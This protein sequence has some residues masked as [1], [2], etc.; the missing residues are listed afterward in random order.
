MRCI[1]QLK[2]VFGISPPSKKYN[3]PRTPEVPVSPTFF[4]PVIGLSLPTGVT[5]NLIFTVINS[6]VFLN[7]FLPLTYR[8]FLFAIFMFHGVTTNTKLANVEP[9]L[10]QEIQG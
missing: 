9:L 10:L 8:S 5:T 7:I 1:I 3:L 2:L 6:C 4:F